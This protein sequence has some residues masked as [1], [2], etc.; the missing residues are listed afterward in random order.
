[1][2][3]SSEALY[4]RVIHASI[5]AASLKGLIRLC[6]RSREEQYETVVDTFV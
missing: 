3:T 5:K 4:S 1:M 6:C 2:F